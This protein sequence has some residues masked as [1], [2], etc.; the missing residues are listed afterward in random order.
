LDDLLIY[1][2]LVFGPRPEGGESDVVVVDGFFGDVGLGV[3]EFADVV[4]GDGADVGVCEVVGLQVSLE[5]V[6]GAGV[7]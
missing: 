3:E 2:A 1:E 6:E 4:A 5:F 7:V